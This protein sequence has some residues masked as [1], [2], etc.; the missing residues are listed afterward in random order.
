VLFRGLCEPTELGEPAAAYAGCVCRW[1]F[2]GLVRE[3]SFLNCVQRLY[4][5]FGRFIHVL[6]TTGVDDSADRR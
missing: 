5:N 1:H 3:P 6:S 4:F 2:Y